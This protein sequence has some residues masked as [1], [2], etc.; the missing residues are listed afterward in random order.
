[1]NYLAHIFL[2]GKNDEVMIGNFIADSTTNKM[3]K[4][5]PED[6]RKGVFLHRKIDS[7]TDRHPSV[8]EA[9]K[10]LNR[11]HGKYA[12]VLLDIFF[13]YFLIKNWKKYSKEEFE[14]FRIRS[15]RILEKYMDWIPMKMRKNL[16]VMIASDWLANYGKL[17]GI[18]FTIGKVKSRVS[19]PDFLE[20]PIE[21]IFDHED[22]LNKN[23]NLFFPDLQQV[24]K[25]EMKILGIID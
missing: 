23:F 25:E 6:I 15:Y 5:L 13:D 24:V 22:L 9:T 19:K 10:L 4:E 8:K 2:S 18:E 1:M 7:F 14:I 17:E 11:A 12:P 3:V 16:P 20:N 21:S